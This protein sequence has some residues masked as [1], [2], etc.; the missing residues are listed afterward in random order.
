MGK[1]IVSEWITLDG[2]F[3]ADTMNEWFIPYHSDSR[4]AYI[5]EGILSCN[6]ILMGRK[7]YEMLAPYWSSL[8]NNEMGIADKMNN[9]P[10]YVV[11]STMK[12]ADWNNTTIIKEN[13]IDEI[14]GLKRQTNGP[15]L[16][17]GSAS[18]VHSLMDTD[19]IDE[20]RFLIHPVI[21]GSGKRFFNNEM[22]H[23]SMNHIE[24]KTLDM[25]VTP[26]CYQPV[27]KKP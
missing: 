9:T 27:I 21:M 14:T 18:L 20:Y 5:Q 7:T 1:L 6:A 24:T 15:I 2:V 8:K 22:Q 25:G 23:I 12:K 13:S 26:L 19:L 3:D 17:I 11:S 4:A 10:K 16:L